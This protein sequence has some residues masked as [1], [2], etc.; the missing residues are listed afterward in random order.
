MLEEKEISLVPRVGAN[1]VLLLS[2]KHVHKQ[3]HTYTQT[4][5]LFGL[6]LFILIEGLM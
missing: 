2:Y 5:V 1:V 4:V 6:L 3:K